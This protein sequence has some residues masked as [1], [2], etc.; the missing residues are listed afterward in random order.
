MKS[1]RDEVIAPVHEMP[2]SAPVS[3]GTV[4]KEL[5]RCPWCNTVAPKPARLCKG[6]GF[7]FTLPETMRK[8]P[9]CS[10]D[11][12]A[13]SILCPTCRFDLE[14]YYHKMKIKGI[15]LEEK[16]KEFVTE[17]IIPAVKRSEHGISGMIH[18]GSQDV[19]SETV[20]E[21]I[22]K[23]KEKQA[24]ILLSRT[25]APQGKRCFRCGAEIPALTRRCPKCKVRLLLT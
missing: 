11:V 19:S 14:A 1:R 25:G 4:N 9:R 2:G 6:C 13:F 8:C 15:E 7:R 16:V 20:Q 10:G 5:K 22:R 17:K 23:S 18:H 21:D 3:V 12:F 24:M